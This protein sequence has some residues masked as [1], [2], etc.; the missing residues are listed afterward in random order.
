MEEGV[1]VLRERRASV[2]GMGDIA[3]GRIAAQ[4]ENGPAYEVV[5]R[6]EF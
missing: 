6:R 2:S 3:A 1:R 5:V 4:V